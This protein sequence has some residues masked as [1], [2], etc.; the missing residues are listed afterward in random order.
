MNT[1][2]FLSVLGLALGATLLGFELRVKPDDQNAVASRLEGT[3]IPDEELGARLGW[4]KNETKVVR[5]ER[6]DAITAQIPAK[7]EES[8]GDQQIFMAGRVHWEEGSHTVDSPFLLIS[9]RGN[10]HLLLWREKNGDPLGDGESC[11]LMVVPAR[12]KANDL[13][14]LGGDHLHDGFNAFRRQ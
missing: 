2:S 5:F 9:H 13:L 4:W 3:W 14:F 12:E 6:D 10:P 1:T 11:N 7:Y 8:L